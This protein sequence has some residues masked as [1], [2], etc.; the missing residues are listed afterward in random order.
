MCVFYLIGLIEARY[1]VSSPPMEV[2]SM[3]TKRCKIASKTS[4]YA[5]VDR[6]T[7]RN[8]MT[9]KS[10]LQDVSFGD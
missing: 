9:T 1:G 2:A 5:C 8:V 4:R 10:H 7:L 6:K 3:E